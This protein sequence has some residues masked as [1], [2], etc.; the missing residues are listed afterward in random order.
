MW[1]SSDSGGEKQSSSLPRSGSGSRIGDGTRKRRGSA[2]SA[3][4]AASSSTP[5]R[6]TTKSMGRNRQRRHRRGEQQE[7]EHDI[8]TRR[9]IRQNEHLRL[10]RSMFQ[11]SDNVVG[12][13]FLLLSAVDEADAYV[14]VAVELMHLLRFIC[15][16]VIAI[17]KICKKHDRLLANRMLGGYY[18]MQRRDEERRRNSFLYNKRKHTGKGKRGHHRG[19]KRK[20]SRLNRH[21][22]I[23]GRGNK[24]YNLS[25]SSPTMLGG[26]LAVSMSD[27]DGCSAAVT[28]A[29]EQYS[30]KVIPS[31][32][33]SDGTNDRLLGV[34]DARIQRLANSSTVQMIS[35][36]L[37]LALSEYEI[38]HSRADALSRPNNHDVYEVMTTPS[39]KR[40]SAFVEH[41]RD[42][43]AAASASLS[44]HKFP[45][46]PR[47]IGSAFSLSPSRLRQA[48]TTRMTGD[49]M[50]IG[51]NDSMDEIVSTNG[52]DGG[53]PSTTSTISLT[54][55]RFAV[56]SV[57]GL[58][59]A[60]RIKSNRF[61]T[62]LSRS[63]VAYTGPHVVG[64]GMDGCSRETLDFFVSY[65]PDAALL[66]DSH[67]LFNCTHAS[68]MEGYGIGS[69]MVSSLAIAAAS[70]HLVYPSARTNQRNIMKVEDDGVV[71]ITTALS[72]MPNAD[73]FDSKMS[74]SIKAGQHHSAERCILSGATSISRGTIIL[75]LSSIL[76]FM[77][78]YYIICPT[79]RECAQL[80][81]AK[82]AHSAVIIGVT[83]VSSLIWSIVQR[84]IIV[85]HKM[86]AKSPMDPSFFFRPMLFSAACPMLGNML[87]SYAFHHCSMWIAI[88]G[89]FLVGFGFS[90]VLSRHLITSC[91]FPTRIVPETANFILASMLGFF[92]GPFVG[93]TL[94]LSEN[95]LIIFGRSINNLALPGHI[96]SMF[97]L[98]QIVGLL[99]FFKRPEYKKKGDAFECDEEHLDHFEISSDT[100]SECNGEPQE[101]DRLL[102]LSSPH[103]PK[104]NNLKAAYGS[105]NSIVVE[106][107]SGDDHSLNK[108]KLHVHTPVRTLSKSINR[109]RKLVFHNM[110]LPVTLAIFAYV[111]LTIEVIFSSCAIITHRYFKWSPSFTGVFLAAL[112][113]A[114]LPISFFVAHNNTNERKLMKVSLLVLET[115]TIITTVSTNTLTSI[116]FCFPQGHFEIYCLWSIDNGQCRGIVQTGSSH[117]E[118][119]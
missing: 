98:L 37:A 76:L 112:A 48:M 56:A 90:E 3:A 34:H 102:L 89:R 74:S 63:L 36:S 72:I 28:N 84:Y 11:R 111:N 61:S 27:K 6:R 97:W 107:L 51:R 40:N 114:V 104:R 110:A 60:A 15:V 29:A 45:L 91:I 1:A 79:A 22:N 55:L 80:F 62:F 38:S 31:C 75:N 94:Y 57:F 7:E 103:T 19:R 18:H 86:G 53:P 109:V 25:P 88:C 113:F 42:K 13:D 39:Q 67:L 96:M 116:L 47:G 73:I 119:F 8:E 77:T 85:R 12:E 49:C 35:S 30:G 92:I 81:G 44:T 41:D 59:E 50:G 65:E 14:M 66:L 78:N 52:E 17:R 20:P 99:C 83:N 10:S 64:D 108:R 4:S 115:K 46:S 106:S 71:D 105:D 58:R 16:N 32:I 21:N 100:T 117:K 23:H 82:S 54:R 68:H 26:I 5:K 69:V 101:T 70:G 87:Y 95:D 118:N 93:A 24:K 9:Q 33:N 43:M 2:S